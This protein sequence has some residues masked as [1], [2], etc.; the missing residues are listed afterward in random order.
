M[1]RLLFEHTV[2]FVFENRAGSVVFGVCPTPASASSCNWISEWVSLQ[3]K[4]LA[5]FDRRVTYFINVTCVNIVMIM[6]DKT[7]RIISFITFFICTTSLAL[8]AASLTT[9]RWL[10]VRPL[11]VSLLNETTIKVYDNNRED[12]TILVTP[13]LDT[14]VAKGAFYANDTSTNQDSRTPL[15]KTLERRKYRG[16]IH[17]GLFQGSKILNYGFGDRS[18]YIASKFISFYT[19]K[20]LLLSMMQVHIS[21]RSQSTL[22][23]LR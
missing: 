17:F 3:L 2:K 7:R 19:P 8:L 13:D 16:Q 15:E 10:V 20:V 23:R 1:T 18:S 4:R 5:Y 22:R 14:A 6:M 21:S 11:R 12:L 9:H